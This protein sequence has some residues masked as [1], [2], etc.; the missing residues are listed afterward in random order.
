[1]KRYIARSQNIPAKSDDEY[2]SKSD[3]DNDQGPPIGTNSPVSSDA[4]TI[5]YADSEDDKR[6]PGHSSG[7]PIPGHTS[8]S[9]ETIEIELRQIPGNT[10][11]QHYSWAYM[12]TVIHVINS[13]ACKWRIYT[14][15]FFVS[16]VHSPYLML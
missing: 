7:V 11:G 6:I 15:M 10:H 12:C 1:M 14:C 9:D 16:N 5:L 3:G 8:S 2:A 13:R 4:D